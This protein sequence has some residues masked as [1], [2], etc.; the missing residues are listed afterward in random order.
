M[1]S[2]T[3]WAEETL[4]ER[5]MEV[6]QMLA[7]GHTAIGIGKELWL[8]EETIKGYR[9][10]VIRKLGARNSCHAVATGLRRGLIS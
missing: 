2:A 8:S 3:P 4:T 1:R 7:D 5:E 6:L 9:K 10:G